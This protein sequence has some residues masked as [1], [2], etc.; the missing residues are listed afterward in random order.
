VPAAVPCQEVLDGSSFA[1]LGESGSLAEL[2]AEKLQSRGGMRLEQ[3]N[4][5]EASAIVYL[6]GISP[7]TANNPLRDLFSFVQSVDAARELRL[8]VCA[9]TTH[10]QHGFGGFIRSIAKER[11]RWTA[12]FIELDAQSTAAEQADIA[13][14]ELLSSD[15]P[16]EVAYS[17]LSRRTPRLVLAATN[18]AGPGLDLGSESV[19]LVTGGARGITAAITAQLARRFGCRLIV[20][21]KSAMSKEEESPELAGLAEAASIRRF[22]VS[23]N[24]YR[25]PS[26]VETEMKRI[27]AVREIRQTL[28]LIQEAGSLV[29]YHPLDVCDSRALA[30]LIGDV[31]SRHKRIDGVIHGAGVIEDKL[32]NDKTWDSF[33][34]VCGTKL[35]AAQTLAGALRDDVR[36]VVF[37]SSVAG[38]L[39]NR[40]Q[41]DYAAASQALN[42]LAAELNNRFSGRVVSISWGPWRGAGMVTRE[43]ENEFLRR[44]VR[45]IDLNDGVEAFFQELNAGNPADAQVVWSACGEES[46]P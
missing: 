36:F 28:N 40:G 30:E 27:L 13:W 34:R 45:L 29:E 26:A 2:I 31:Y 9:A 24:G 20:V 23:R 12:R 25:D 41:A 33:A 38:E 7:A 10:G 4:E 43:L 3:G 18:G 16:P 42:R 44:G 35:S 21:G 11:P 22:L 37:F 14:R 15:G 39:G 8:L 46:F 6:A 19:V 32:I 5:A 17:G 1:V